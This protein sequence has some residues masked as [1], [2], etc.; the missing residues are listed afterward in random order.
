MRKLYLISVEGDI[1]YDEYSSVLVSSENRDRAISIALDCCSNFNLKNV[2]CE[3]IGEA[4]K[5]VKEGILMIDF[6]AG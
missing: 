5:W 3:L 2:N 4:S 1:D 6:H